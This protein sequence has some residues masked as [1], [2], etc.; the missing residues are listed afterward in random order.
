MWPHVLD[1]HGFR[2][3]FNADYELGMYSSLRRGVR[4]P[5]GWRA[6]RFFVL[7]ADCPLVRGETVGRLLRAART[8]DAL[9]IYPRYNG[10][11]GHPPLLDATLIPLILSSEP[12]DGLRGILA[13]VEDRSFDVEVDDA[14]VLLDMDLRADYEQ[15]ERLAQLERVPDRRACEVLLQQRACRRRGGTQRRRGACGPP[16][17]GGAER[18]GNGPQRAATRGRRPAARHRPRPGPTTRSAARSCSRRWA[19]PVWPRSWRAIWISRAGATA[20]LGEEALLFL[21][22]KLVMGTRLVTLPERWRRSRRA[23]RMI[24]RP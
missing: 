3:V 18:G 19:F 15:L 6:A 21:A 9:V 1:A 4:G 17:G 24:H 11:R 13:T 2:H 12:D 20:D 10:R 5:A 14:G 8:R 22:D 7:P 16:S 23:S